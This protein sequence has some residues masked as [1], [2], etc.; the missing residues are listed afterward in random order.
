MKSA[1]LFATLIAIGVCVAQVARHESGE[2]YIN[3]QLKIIE[4]HKALLVKAGRITD[5]SHFSAEVYLASYGW[6]GDANGS[7]GAYTFYAPAFEQAKR[8]FVIHGEVDEG[9]NI[10]VDANY[11]HYVEDERGVTELSS[12]NVGKGAFDPS[13]VGD[14]VPGLTYCESYGN[15]NKYCDEPGLI[16]AKVIKFIDRG[17][18]MLDKTAD[19][20]AVMYGLTI[21][22]PDYVDMCGCTVPMSAP[23]PNA[24]PCV[25]GGTLNPG[26]SCT[27][28]VTF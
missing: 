19:H 11:G 28:A 5:P 7:F 9:S 12:D 24:K 14:T 3:R 15:H 21:T 20:D 1:I 4:A 23:D 13:I 22:P 8:I 17:H 10:L 26:E 6:H 18:V 25:Q 16:G 27:M 2:A